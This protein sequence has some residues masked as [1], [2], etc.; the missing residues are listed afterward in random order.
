MA[1]K[2]AHRTC[3]NLLQRLR[4]SRSGWR[5]RWKL[6]DDRLHFAEIRSRNSCRI[7]AG[8]WIV[9]QHRTFSKVRS[10][11]LV[12]P[13][14][15]VLFPAAVVPMWIEA[16]I[17]ATRAR[18]DGRVRIG[19]I[20]RSDARAGCL[21]DPLKRSRW[22]RMNGFGV[23]CCFVIQDVI[24]SHGRPADQQH[25]HDGKKKFAEVLHWI[26]PEKSTES[27]VSCLIID[28]SRQ[29]NNDCLEH[30]KDRPDRQIPTGTHERIRSSSM[31][32]PLIARD[33]AMSLMA[34]VSAVTFSKDVLQHSFPS[35]S[36]RE[37]R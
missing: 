14:S 3:R 4:V 18:T 30:W 28:G 11:P 2:Q 20:S 8:T 27:L 16:S 36:L 35:M 26:P 34:Q 31:S 12:E 23:N 13:G 24:L 17:V 32:K 6:I 1:P 25:R 29:R 22:L 19:D 21:V 10:H 5:C 33:E 9:I 15:L 7:D 37:E